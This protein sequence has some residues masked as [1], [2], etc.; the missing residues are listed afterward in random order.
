M[1][2]AALDREREAVGAAKD[3][4]RFDCNSS[5][6]ERRPEVDAEH[7]IHAVGGAVVDH[8]HGARSRLLRGLEAEAE[9]PAPAVTQGNQGRGGT[10]GH[11]HVPVVTA[12]VHDAVGLGVHN[13]PVAALED[14]QGVH[15]RSQHQHRPGLATVEISDDTGAAD[16]G[17]NCKPEGGAA[18]REHLGGVQLA[19]G[20]LRVA[21]EGAPGLDHLL[22]GEVDL[23]P[24]AGLEICRGAA[25]D[26]S[27]T[28][29]PERR[30]ATTCSAPLL[31]TRVAPAA[32]ARR[33]RSRS[34]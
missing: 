34:A 5:G 8:R 27:P 14:R 20:D 25:H 30:S 11:R 31:M 33:R 29:T 17:A 7:A 32:R 23:R 13:P 26:P 21:V 19:G 15:V 28:L 18:L 3:H 6:L 1:P 12:G 24:Y 10:E 16:T 22:A 9:A 2:A 4:A